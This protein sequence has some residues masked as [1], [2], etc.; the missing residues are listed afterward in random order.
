MSSIVWNAYEKWNG[1]HVYE[2]NMKKLNV[3][4]MYKVYGEVNGPFC[5]YWDACKMLFPMINIVINELWKEDILNGKVYA[6][7]QCTDK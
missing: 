3:F 6:L 2:M 1:V 7:S 4:K 5:V